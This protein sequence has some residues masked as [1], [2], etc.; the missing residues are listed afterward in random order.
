MTT[1]SVCISNLLQHSL[2][3]LT[4]RW[5]GVAKGDPCSNMC[6]MRL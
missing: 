1:K 2:C 4:R 3:M 6:T 5:T